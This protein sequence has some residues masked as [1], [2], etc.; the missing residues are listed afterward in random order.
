M[1]E[2]SKNT[3]QSYANKAKYD[4]D[5]DA[6]WIKSDTGRSPKEQKE[7]DPDHWSTRN[8]VKRDNGIKAAKSR[9]IT[10]QTRQQR[11]DS[12]ERGDSNNSHPDY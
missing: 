3:T 5:S 12:R 2:L 4:R 8:L 1:N 10:P 9:G 11:I 6:R 7:R